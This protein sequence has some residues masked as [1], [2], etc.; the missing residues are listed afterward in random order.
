M[1]FGTPERRLL[2]RPDMHA[3]NRFNDAAC[4]PRGRLWAGTMHIEASRDREPTGALYRLDASGLVPFA[5]DIGIANG[6]GWSPDGGTMYFAETHRGTI[7]AYDYDVATGIPS[8][9]RIL[10]EVPD[11]IGVPDGLT[12]DSAGRILR[13]AFGAV[14]GSTST[15]RDGTLDQVIAM[16]VPS[17]TS[18][19]LGGPDLCTLYITTDGRGLSGEH[20]DDPLPGRL[21]A[22]DWDVP[23]VPCPRMRPFDV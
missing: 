12:V 17:P 13:R 18:C 15:R 5:T 7:W 8:N 16:P 14:R 22:L 9:R 1:G 10:A 4:D 3:E 19:C 20:A 11:E 23:G 21:F 6:L 2:A